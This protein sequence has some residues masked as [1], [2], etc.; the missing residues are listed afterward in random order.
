M[1][2]KLFLT[3]ILASVMS[4]GAFAQT[5]TEVK[6]V[7]KEEKIVKTKK[8]HGKKIEEK[9]EEKVEEKKEETKK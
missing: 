7:K 5:G 2:T 6:E 4:F 8:K 3:M 9:K 1:K